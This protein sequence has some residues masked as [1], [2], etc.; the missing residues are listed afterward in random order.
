[1]LSRF[2]TKCHNHASLHY[3]SHDHVYFLTYHSLKQS[4]M[5]IVIYE[6][7]VRRLWIRIVSQGV[8]CVYSVV[9]GGCLL[10]HMC[11]F[12]YPCGYTLYIFL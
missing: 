6:V 11:F 4:Y 5:E 12:T 2:Y 8:V 1:M 3:T 9:I 10:D 7:F